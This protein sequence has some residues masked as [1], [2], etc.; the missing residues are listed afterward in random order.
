MLKTKTISILSS[1]R[2]LTTGSTDLFICLKQTITLWR[3]FN[4]S[5]VGWDD[6]HG[7]RRG[8]WPWRLHS[9]DVPPLFLPIALG[10]ENLVF[11]QPETQIE[12]EHFSPPGCCH[13]VNRTSWQ[14]PCAFAASVRAWFRKQSRKVRSL[15]KRALHGMCKARQLA[16]RPAL[17]ALL[18]T[19][20]D[21][22]VFVGETTRV[23]TEKVLCAS[24]GTYT[25]GS[26]PGT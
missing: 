7:D 18:Q 13:L 16:T 24:S 9:Q 20:S 6:F 4:W 2:I 21:V 14:A 10:P 1:T 22:P 8:T 23:P 17:A 19:S 11:S 12:T 26:L 15:A 5:G 25:I 3:T